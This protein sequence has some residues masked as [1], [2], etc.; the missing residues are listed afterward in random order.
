[1]TKTSVTRRQF[2]NIGGGVLAAGVAAKTTLFDPTLLSARSV[3]R[4]A[5][6]PSD[7]IRFASIGTGVRGC[8][9]LH[10][11][12]SVPGVQCVGICDLYDGRHDAGRQAVQIN[13]VPVTRSYKVI[14]DR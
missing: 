14:L 12:L 10:A 4:G 7:T 13:S 5:V 11:T 3:A 9:L 2:I 8:E 1:M 6:P